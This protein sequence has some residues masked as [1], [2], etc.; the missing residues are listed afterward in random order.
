M[1]EMAAYA[2]K[3]CAETELIEINNMSKSNFSYVAVS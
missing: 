2:N 1:F 3:T